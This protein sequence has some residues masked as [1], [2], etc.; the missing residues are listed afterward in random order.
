MAISPIFQNVAQTATPANTAAAPVDP[1]AGIKMSAED[2]VRSLFLRDLNRLPDPAGQTFWE[3]RAK[4]VPPA[5]LNAEFRE[6]AKAENPQAGSLPTPYSRATLPGQST[7]TERNKSFLEVVAPVII[8]AVAIFAPTL[9]PSIGA[10]LGATNAIAANAIGSAVVNAGVTAATGGSASDILRAGLAGAAGGAA[11]TYAGQAVGGAFPTDSLT[12]RALEAGARGAAGTGAATLVQTGDV[13]QALKAGAI[14]GLAGGAGELASTGAQ[15]LLPA[16]AGRTTQALVAGGIGGATEAAVQGQDPLLG[17]ITSAAL[18]TGREIQRENQTK[19]A[20][21]VMQQIID[22]AATDP[23]VNI[24]LAQALPV[25]AEQVQQ[26]SR[27]GESKAAESILRQAANDPKFIRTAAN[28]ASLEVL[29]NA[30]YNTLA[31]ALSQVAVGM[32]TLLTPGNVFQETNEDAIMAEKL[33][34][35][36]TPIA[37]TDFALAPVEVVANKNFGKL[38]PNESIGNAGEL[39]ENGKP[40]GLFVDRAGTLYDE[41]GNPSIKNYAPP[42]AIPPSVTR[43]GAPIS[44]QLPIQPISPR[45][46]PGAAPITAP[47]ISPEITP[48]T[49]PGITPAPA[50]APAPATT[51]TPEAV[52]SPEPGRRVS[53][54][55]E[56]VPEPAPRPVPRPSTTPTRPITPLPPITPSGTAPSGGTPSIIPERD[57]AIMD[58]TGL[59]PS[60]DITPIDRLPEVEAA[61]PPDE[62]EPTRIKPEEDF[63]ASQTFPLTQPDKSRE[64]INYLYGNINQ[65][66]F[67]LQ[68]GEMQP[69]TSALAQALGVGDPGASYL[70]KKGKERRPVWNIESLKL[71]DELGGDYG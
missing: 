14:G 5:Q 28:E 29:R 39:L 24:Q 15:Q 45:P 60:P 31:N 38:A 66:P 43:V 51:P 57:R 2:Q 11:G 36:V 71:K 56:P 12:G 62:E 65:S 70:G 7:Y 47:S 40:T 32:T 19:Q 58:L 27:M 25:T 30:G 20:A 41:A 64:L 49:A 69:G 18:T 37:S 61:I 8:P 59:V 34:Q 22:T 50:T 55:P 63:R 52:P 68:P 16:G 26:L 3:Q 53:P 35:F 42:S 9:L 17:G 46:E 21:N 6:A 4:E 48:T 44:P 23:A 13:G 10:Q 1:R 54:V 33:K 67:L